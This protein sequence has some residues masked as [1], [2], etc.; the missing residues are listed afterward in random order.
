MYTELDTENFIL[1]YAER[2]LYRLRL[3]VD[4]AQESYEIGTQITLRCILPPSLLRSPFVTTEWRT[5]VPDVLPYTGY[6]PPR[7]QY[8]SDRSNISFIIPAHHPMSAN[9]YCSVH[10]VEYPIVELVTEGITLKV[11]GMYI[12]MMMDQQIASCGQL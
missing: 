2:E 4:P 12:I 1:L 8:E 9:Y 3:E 6:V 11:K 10:S 7:M 5:A